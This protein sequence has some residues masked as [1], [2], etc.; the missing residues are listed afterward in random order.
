MKKTLNSSAGHSNYS[1]KTLKLRD[2]N[3]SDAGMRKLTLPTRMFGKG[4]VN[5]QTLILSDN[6]GITDKSL[7]SL[8]CYRMLTTVDLSNTSATRRGAVELGQKMGLHL[9]SAPHKCQV[10][11]DGWAVPILSQWQEQMEEAAAQRKRKRQL[12]SPTKTGLFSYK[13]RVCLWQL[14]P[15]KSPGSESGSLVLRDVPDPHVPVSPPSA[16]ARKLF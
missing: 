11:N 10:T 13:K 9:S 3:L 2:V 1:L 16:A 7:H 4:P 5:L 15:R 8:S 12:D 6:G 14:S